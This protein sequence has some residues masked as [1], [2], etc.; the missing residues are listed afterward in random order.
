MDEGVAHLCFVKTAVT[1]LHRKVEK[2]IP[3]KRGGAE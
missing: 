2:S 3:R 1:Y